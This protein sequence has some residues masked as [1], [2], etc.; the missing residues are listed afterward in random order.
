MYKIGVKKDFN[1]KKGSI[2]LGA[3]N[4]L[5]TGVDI[6]RTELTA[7]TF[8]QLSSTHLFNRGFELTF[9]YN[10]GKVGAP[11]HKKTRSVKNEDVK[12]GEN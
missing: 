2:G 10:I 1:N 3:E 12:E 4:F 5:T 9:D 8:S 7:P 11:Q 6:M